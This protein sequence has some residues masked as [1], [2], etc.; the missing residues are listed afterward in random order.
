MEANRL[1]RKKSDRLALSWNQRRC[2]N[3]WSL[4]NYFLAFWRTVN[5]TLPNISSI[6]CVQFHRMHRCKF[7]FIRGPK[8]RTFLGLISV[9]NNFRPWFWCYWFFVQLHAV[10]KW[11]SVTQKSFVLLSCPYSVSHR[12]KKTFETNIIFQAVLVGAALNIAIVT[13]GWEFAFGPILDHLKLIGWNWKTKNKWIETI[14]FLKDGFES[15]IGRLSTCKNL[16][17]VRFGCIFY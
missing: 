1:L 7:I 16:I 2:F 14:L 10:L 15:L 9:L 8:G 3:Q 12:P 4:W 5:S 13:L 17:F 6:Y 11:D